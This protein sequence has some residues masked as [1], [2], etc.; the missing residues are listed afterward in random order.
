MQS[1]RR[2]KICIIGASAV[3]KTSIV[4][5]FT[6]GTFFN[7]YQTT[8]GA[9]VTRVTVAIGGRLKEL[10]VW[11][12]KGENEFYHIPPDYL[13]GCDGYVLVADGTRA[14]TGEYALGLRTRLRE[15]LGTL[16]HIMLVNKADLSQVWD[17]DEN[18]LASLS[19]QIPAVYKVSALTGNGIHDAM[20]ALSRELWGMK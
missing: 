10:V 5:R 6:G 2:K 8:Q 16:P 14:S 13:Y 9:H 3:G 18:M 12:I 4:S 1:L 20:D 19:R 7:R 11:D 17:L 15:I